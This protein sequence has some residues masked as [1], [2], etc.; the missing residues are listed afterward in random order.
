[1]LKMKSKAKF[2]ANKFKIK[3]EIQF[4]QYLEMVS[5]YSKILP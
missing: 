1:M 3:Y 4:K 2:K 5:K